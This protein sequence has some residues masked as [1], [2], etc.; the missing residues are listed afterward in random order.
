MS[1]GA[2]VLEVRGRVAIVRLDRPDK[3]NALTP[4]M[5]AEL[6]QAVATIDRDPELRVAVVTGAGRAFCA[7]SDIRTL[8]DYATPW[9]FGQRAD[10]GDILRRLRT[11][12]IAAVNGAA[13]GGGLELA[14][15]CD[16]R[17]A[18]TTALFGAPEI[19]LGWIGGSGQ[20]ALLARSVGPSNAARMLLTGDPIDAATA[21]AWGLVTE[22]V[23]PEALMDAALALAE[24]IA[25]RAPL[26]AQMAKVNL[27]AA[28]S[29]PL[30]EAIALERHLQTVTLATADADEGRAAFAERRPPE[31]RG[32]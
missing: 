11:P 27:H 21:A 25:S 30:D 1:D 12:T 7:G 4:A 29:M 17:I 13:V 14:M 10:Y 19:K 2:V 22:V 16:I 23:E 26:A 5:T 18:S 31:F 9:D 6:A 15:A 24:T 32:R 20:S 28:A 8:D 3:L